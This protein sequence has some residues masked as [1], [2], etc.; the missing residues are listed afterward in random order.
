MPQQLCTSLERRSTHLFSARLVIDVCLAPIERGADLE[1][2]QQEGSDA[3]V[4]SLYP[5]TE[6]VPERQHPTE[7]V[8]IVAQTRG[9]EP[10][11]IEPAAG[12]GTHEIVEAVLRRGT[13]SPLS[14]QNLHVR[15]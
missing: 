11:R 4:L 13:A 5:P 2:W 1:P 3:L 6:R 9:V 12:R 14:I 15:P 8:H 10:R 7:I